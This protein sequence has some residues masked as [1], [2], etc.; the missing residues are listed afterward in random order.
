M[1][2]VKFLQNGWPL[3]YVR[4]TWPDCT[5]RRNHAGA[6][7][8]PEFIDAWL[9]REVELGRMRGPFASP[10][11]E[12]FVVSPLNTVEKSD[13]TERRVIVDLSW[14]HGRSVNYGIDLTILYSE[15]I[16]G[17]RY[18]SIDNIIALVN[19]YGSG[20]FLYKCDL[21]AA[22][23]QFRVAEKDF[24]LLGYFWKGAYYYDCRLC[25][26]Q[27][28]AAFGCQSATGAVAFIHNSRGGSVVVYIDDFIGVDS[29]LN[30]KQSFRDL[31]ALLKELGLE[32]NE[33]KACLPATEQVCL[34]VLINSVDMTISITQSRLDDIRR[35][36]DAWARKR[37]ATKTELQSLIGANVRLQVCPICSHFRQSFARAFAIFEGRPEMQVNRG[38]SQGYSMVAYFLG[39][40]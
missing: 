26:G 25:M 1:D 14:P 12:N 3:G 16:D 38:I 29:P 28:S 15:T 24:H 18:P 34:G 21:R 31:R 7:E 9:I 10:P 11:L 20:C 30:A 37:L 17:L 40:A 33:S 39:N 6:R 27:R 22:Y 32:E 13:S 23:R 8:F 19:A 5:Q 36:V 4:D 2:I 35:L